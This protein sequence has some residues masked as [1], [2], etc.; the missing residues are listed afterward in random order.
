MGYLLARGLMPLLGI[1][2]GIAQT[3]LAA[4]ST[5]ISLAKP[6]NLQSTEVSIFTP[7]NITI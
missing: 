3:H 1:L 6:S 7:S 4:L 5:A 2:Y